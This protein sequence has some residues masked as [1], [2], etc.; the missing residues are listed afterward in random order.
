MKK[1]FFYLA[2]A[3]ISFIGL[4]ACS[5]DTADL[6][7]SNPNDTELLSKPSQA[8][9][10]DPIALIAINA[11]FSELV[12]ALI[13]VDQ[14]LDAGLVNLFLNG[15][16]Q[17]TV[18]APTNQAFYDLYDALGE[19]V[20]D[21]TD[22]PAELVRD[23][24]LYHVAEGRRGSNSVVPRNGERTITT[25]GGGTFMV[26]SSGM[27]TANNSMAYIDTPNISASNGII[28]IITAVLLP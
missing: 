18:F 23:V 4:T 9:G 19:G 17:Y 20:N 2:I 21:I 12:S 13:Y 15:T 16:D 11:G 28:H 14:S 7:L 25:L 3:S 10:D 24:L 26:N 8:P 27:I 6:N 22:L 1:I 5:D